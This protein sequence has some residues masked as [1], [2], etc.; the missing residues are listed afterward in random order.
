[1]P[2]T[3]ALSSTCS[4]CTARLAALP[5][6]T[7]LSRI[8]A[9]GGPGLGSGMGV[10]GKHIAPPVSTPPPGGA[11]GAHRSRLGLSDAWWYDAACLRTKI[12]IRA[13][14]EILVQLGGGAI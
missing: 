3:Q 6:V 11:P 10:R 4:N 9:P 13:K 14:T 2:L 1:M 5:P 12:E 7:P 8:G